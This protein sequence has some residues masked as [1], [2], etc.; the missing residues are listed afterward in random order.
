MWTLAIAKT[1]QEITCF[2]FFVFFF[3]FSFYIAWQRFVFFTAARAE[4]RRVS[5][6]DEMIPSIVLFPLGF[7]DAER[8]IRVNL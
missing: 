2:P 8:N 5:L 1:F 7:D 6:S 3:C 4:D